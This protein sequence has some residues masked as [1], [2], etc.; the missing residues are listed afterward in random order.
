MNPLIEIKRQRIFIDHSSDAKT[1]INE[2]FTVRALQSK[3]DNI[4]IIKNN[5]MPNLHVYDS[6]GEDLPIINNAVTLDLLERQKNSTKSDKL[7][8]QKLQNYI[9]RMKKKEIYIIWVKLPPI[10]KMKKNQLRII[11]FKYDSPKETKPS[12]KIKTNYARNLGH[13]VFYIIKKPEDYDFKGKPQ[14][15][16]TDDNDEY[17]LL[18]KWDS[19][20]NEP[21]YI[22]QTAYTFSVTIK[23]RMIKTASISYSFTGTKNIVS[24]PL[25]TIS[26]LS[27]FSF[28]I[29]FLHQCEFF[30]V[31][32]QFNISVS[33][34]SSTLLTVNELLEKRIEL[35]SAIAGASLVIPR[36]ISNTNIRYDYKYYFFIPLGLSILAFF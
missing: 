24:F 9:K 2:E 12:S 28:S 17:N 22:T 3:V 32:D 35:L 34:N 14:I 26:L 23:P 15:G 7:T 27:I 8:K 30:S 36:L 25:V 11:N 13:S 5:F 4:I 16:W 21:I 18:E 19:D 10:K 6:D 20:N 31:C 1:F 33:N 29:F